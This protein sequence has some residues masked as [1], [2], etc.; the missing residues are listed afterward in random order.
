M[1]PGRHF[2]PLELGTIRGLPSIAMKA[3]YRA[4]MPLRMPS[5]PILRCRHDA[6]S[7]DESTLH[8]IQ[9]S[10]SWGHCRRTIESK[11]TVR[12]QSRG[13]S[14]SRGQGR[15]AESVLA[16]PCESKNILRRVETSIKCLGG[17]PSTWA[18]PNHSQHLGHPGTEPDSRR[19]PQRIVSTFQVPSVK[20]AWLGKDAWQQQRNGADGDGN[21]AAHSK[22]HLHDARELLNFVLAR[23]QRVPC[24][25]PQPHPHH[26]SFWAIGWADMPWLHHGKAASQATA[27]SGSALLTHGR[28][29]TFWHLD[30]S[31]QSAKPSV[32]ARRTGVQ[33]SEDAAEAPHVDGHVV[34]QTEDD[35]GRAV[36]P[37]P[38]P[39]ARYPQ[40][41]SAARQ[42]TTQKLVRPA[43]HQTAAD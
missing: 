37:G 26:P 34:R 10:G 29:G 32:A 15:G 6:A 11:V 41:G 39:V 8:Q 38:A 36:E 21:L 33:L 4:L 23:E 5:G 40:I 20:K 42:Q 3:C 35:F 13:A 30:P 9:P 27:I 24:R 1:P 25:T 12:E 17:T 22:P 43:A 28:A 7:N 2:L 18:T 31:G 19:R 14:Q 16:L